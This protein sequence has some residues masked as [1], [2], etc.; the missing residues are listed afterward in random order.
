V[1]LHVGSIKN[2]DDLKKLFLIHFFE[3]DTEMSVP[4]LLATKQR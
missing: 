3:D 4:T 2:W 1:K